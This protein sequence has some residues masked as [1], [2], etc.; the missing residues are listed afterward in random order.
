MPDYSQSPLELLRKSR[1]Q[2]YVGI[3]IEQGVPILDRDLNL[4]QDLVAATAR[5]VFTRYIGNGNANGDDG[6]AICALPDD[7]GQN[8]FAIMAGTCLV[9]GVEYTIPEMITYSSQKLNSLTTPT[10]N[11]TD[12]VY[13]DAELVEVDWTTD[14][15]LLNSLDIGIQTSVR[16]K[17][18]CVVRVHEGSEEVPPPLAKGHRH[19]LLA[20]LTRPAGSDRIQQSFIADKRQRR[21]TMTDMEIR[22]SEL[23]RLLAPRFAS[24]RPQFEP[25]SG[26]VNQ[27]VMLNGRNFH[28]E[29]TQVYFGKTKADVVGTGALNQIVAQVPAGLTTGPTDALVLLTVLNTVGTAVSTSRFTVS[30]DPVF[31]APGGQFSPDHGTPESPVDI[32]GFNFDTDGTPQ[33]LFGEVAS[34]EVTLQSDSLIQAAVPHGLVPLDSATRQVQITL[35]IGDRSVTSDDQFTVEQTVPEPTF[36]M[37]PFTPKTGRAGDLITFNGTNFDTGSL[38][39]FFG[40]KKADNIEGAPSATQFAAKVPEGL[41]PGPLKIRIVT[42]GGSVTSTTNFT[43]ATE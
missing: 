30:A 7:Q 16:I 33:V 9:D 29:G 28:L 19:H 18:V 6:F 37:P 41:E 27:P 38:R 26:V 34:T 43:V 12:C 39:V 2:G 31:A 15:A 23:E 5:E 14:P 36:T 11:R 13:L 1:E 8:D 35:K 4:L 3:H 40:S 17:P 20:L 42:A 32:Y 25:K 24:D 22:L 21:L 10:T